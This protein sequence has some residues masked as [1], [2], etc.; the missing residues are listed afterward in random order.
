LFHYSGSGIETDDDNK[1]GNDFSSLLGT[2]GGPEKGR[3][4]AAGK[5]VSTAA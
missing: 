2:F 5:L 3:F 4:V 1:R